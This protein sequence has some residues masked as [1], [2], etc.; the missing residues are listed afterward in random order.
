[1][2]DRRDRALLWFVFLGPAAAWTGQLLIGYGYN[3]AACSNETGENLQAP[4]IGGVSV[5]LGA[6]TVVAGISGL[7]TWRAVR[8]EEIADPRGRIAFMCVFGMLS[9]VLFLFAVVLG[10]VHVLILD[11]CAPA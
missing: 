3:E 8:R 5:L 4:L 6:A 1:M 2:L 11:P 10:G 7:R 9:S